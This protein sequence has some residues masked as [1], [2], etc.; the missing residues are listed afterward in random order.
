MAKTLSPRFG[1]QRW[2]ADGD[3]Q[4]RT[5]FDDAHAQL[6]AL[7]LKVL[8]G[9]QAARPAAAGGGGVNDLTLF[10]ATAGTET[11][12]ATYSDGVA[13]RD[14]VSRLTVL[15]VTPAAAQVGVTIQQAA[16]P[17]TNALEVVSSAAV[18]LARISSGG[19]ALIDTAGT[20]TGSAIGGPGLSTTRLA[21]HT[22][23]PGAKG[24]VVKLAASQTANALEVQDSSA[25][26]LAR[27]DS[28]GS[29][30][31]PLASINTAYLGARLGVVPG[32][33]SEVGVI[34]QG[35]AA[36]TGNLLEGR[37]SA[38]TPLVRLDPAGSVIT[39]GPTNR[40]GPGTHDSAANLSSAV[41]STTA[42]GL[43]VR[44]AAAQ[45]ANAL[46]VQNSAGGALAQVWADGSFYTQ[47]QFA[48][49]TTPETN[50]RATI[51]TGAAGTRGLVVRSTSGQ[52]A[53]IVEIQDPGGAGLVIVT[54]SGNIQ[55][56]GVFAS[57]STD[58]SY[59]I[60]GNGTNAAKPVLA[61]RGASAQS[62][63]LAEF[64]NNS[65]GLLLS[66]KDAGGGAQLTFGIA[67]SVS[68]PAAGASL[69]VSGTGQLRLRVA[70]GND[71]AIAGP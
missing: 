66:V 24:L 41:S 15:T 30:Y 4:T 70:N 53:N 43:V 58:Q 51:V 55:P 61:V 50:Q 10:V 44:L 33:T 63:N 38:G 9:D 57:T 71:Y 54:A 3:T 45:T 46:E 35:L 62:A 11:G 37:N 22:A 21:V 16:A 67:T 49:G 18:V 56:K 60:F 1:L 65:S 68:T 36:Q 48:A 39:S 6:E 32:S 59:A 26:V 12:R 28:S 8:D 19:D 13:W 31:A 17:S 40:F 42:K 64:L 27:L 34:V 2:S 7:A 69:Y 47:S 29:L 14:L 25:A 20:G 52:T 23:S 5:E